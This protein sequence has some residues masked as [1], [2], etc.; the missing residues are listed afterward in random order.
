MLLHLKDCK[1]PCKVEKFILLPMP[2][3]INFVMDKI[4]ILFLSLL[5]TLVGFSFV[6]SCLWFIWAPTPCPAGWWPLVLYQPQHWDDGILFP[7]SAFISPMAPDKYTTQDP[8]VLM[9]YI[10]LL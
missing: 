7:L 9:L 1:F 10:P 3:H 6:F 5:S 4:Q 2:V 8:S